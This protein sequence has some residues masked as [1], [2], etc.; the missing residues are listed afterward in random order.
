MS[1]TT[2][3]PERARAVG[4]TRLLGN[5]LRV[6]WEVVTPGPFCDTENLISTRLEGE[7]IGTRSGFLGIGS[8]LVVR[9]DNGSIVTVDA[10]DV[11]VLPNEKLSHAAG[12]RDVASGKN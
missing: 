10:D 6:Q 9:M 3:Q 8:Y 11:H 1:E 2:P 7:V 12:D 4:S 5:S